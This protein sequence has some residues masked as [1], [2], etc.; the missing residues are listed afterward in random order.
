MDNPVWKLR[1]VRVSY[2]YV[3]RTFLQKK[4]PKNHSLLFI[5]FLNIVQKKFNKNLDSLRK[6]RKFLDKNEDV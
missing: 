1:K 5:E 6:I 2:D 4:K 3:F